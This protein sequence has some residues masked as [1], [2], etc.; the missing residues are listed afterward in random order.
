MNLQ[1]ITEI[2]VNA[3]REAYKVQ[4]ELYDNGT[5]WQLDN[6]GNGTDKA[7]KGDW[8]S[9]EAVIKYLTDKNFPGVIISEEHGK[10]KLG[11]KYLAVLDGIDGSSAMVKDHK[12]RCGT[13]ISIAN[14]LK[15]TYNDFIFSGITE[16]I[17]NRI[18]YTVKN[19]GVWIV[20]RIGDN[21]IKEKV[22]EFSERGFDDCMT[23]KID[24]YKTDYAKGITKGMSQ[25]EE[26]MNENVVKKLEGKMKLAGSV[27]GSEM[28]LD[29]LERKVEAV[30]HIVA[31][32]VFEIPNMYLMTKELMG[33]GTDLQG[34]DLGNKK[35]KAMKVYDDSMEIDVAIFASS[36]EL[37]NKII[38]YLKS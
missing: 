4:K 12:S 18:A 14:K 16:Y 13:I 37:G 31:K 8:E 22:I 35:W 21:E 9:E 7:T 23:I 2:G 25:F 15:P 5:I 29:L 24:C 11:K 17:T 3:L 26:F 30:A 28:C 36:H 27:T 32:G 6:F 33:V 38:E 20:D 1:E 10:I 19:K 34:N